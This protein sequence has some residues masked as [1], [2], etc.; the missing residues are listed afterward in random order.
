MSIF[1]L[2]PYPEGLL[3]RLSE[4]G[5]N[6]IWM[7]GILYQLTPFPF[8]PSL[9]KGYEKRRE[10]L[11]RLVEKAK[12]FGI[13]IY[14]YFN[15][16]RAMSDAFYRKYPEL[17]GTREG[18]FYA[19]C[20]SDDRVKEYLY[21]GMKDL[22][23]D[24]PDLAGFFTITMSENLTNC[25]SRL[26]RREQECPR[27]KLRKPEEV[28]AE[29]NNLMARGAKAGNPDAKAIAWTWGWNPS[30][31][32][33]VIRSLDEG[34]M[35]MCVNEEGME[36]DIA[37]YHPVVIDYTMTVP[38]PSQR[39]INNW[40]IAKQTGR[41]TLSKVQLNCTWELSALPF[42]PLAQICDE[43]IRNIK[44]Q[45]V[46][47]LMLS[48]TLGGCDSQN[49]DIASLYY[50][51]PTEENPLERYMEKTY[52][53]TVQR[54]M[55]A[56][57]IF[58]EA[59][60]MF[61]FHLTVLY[62]A[63]QNYAPAAPF[64]EYKTGYTASMIGFPHDDLQTWKAIYSEEDFQKQFHKLVSKWKEGVNLLEEATEVRNSKFA[65]L[66]RM[67][68]GAYYHFKSTLNHIRFVMERNKLLSDTLTMEEQIQAKKTIRS[69]L[70]DET[71]TVLNVLK[72]RSE[73]SRI[74]F[75][76]SNHYFYTVQDLKEK[77]INLH[78]LK[79]YYA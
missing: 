56:Q 41:K 63:P 35:L 1:S 70:D 22:F 18:D 37:G 34:I 12:R 42:L 49:L 50:E 44:K 65:E 36:L 20:T 51:E 26:G 21:S 76:A 14:M 68:K 71:E 6:G 60:R 27:C 57:E 3:R 58:S 8:E 15:E 2:D 4:C 19:L 62:T 16:P 74:G 46:E 48:W 72:I 33:N 31:T 17:R 77:I 25:Y 5:V 45:G 47:G 30:W 59:M 43:R 67:A 24:I 79:E 29:V 64:Y 13:D 23:S 53:N 9:S 55:K 11:K 54:V 75:E 61:P 32:E 39:A 38:G 66:L 28:V 10:S 69:I 7:Q 52:E 78:Y 73:D 40:T